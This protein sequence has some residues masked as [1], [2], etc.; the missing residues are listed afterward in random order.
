MR[1]LLRE[2]LLVLTCLLFLL[3]KT[4]FLSCKLL[5]HLLLLGLTLGADVSRL[6]ALRTFSFILADTDLDRSI[7]E[8]VCPGMGTPRVALHLRFFFPTP[9][10]NVALVSSRKH[11]LLAAQHGIELLHL[12]YLVLS[13]NT[14]LID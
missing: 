10:L 14:C 7:V 3:L 9:C 5:G 1:V 4:H 6:E 2:L 8:S 12:F 11:N 13:L